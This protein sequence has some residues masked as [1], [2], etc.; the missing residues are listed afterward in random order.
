MCREG[1]GPAGAGPKRA[2]GYVKRNRITQAKNLACG[3]ANRILVLVA[4]GA[5][6]LLALVLGDLCTPNFSSSSHA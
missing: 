4:V 6:L 2:Y 3:Q 1:F 5:A